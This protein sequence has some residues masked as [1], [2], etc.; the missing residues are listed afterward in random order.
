MVRSVVDEDTRED[1]RVMLKALDPD[2]LVD[3]LQIHCRDLWSVDGLYYIF[4]EERYD[5]DVATDIDAQVWQTMGKIEARRLKKLLGLKDNNL[6]SFAEAF[7]YTSWAL[8]LEWKEYEH[9]F[10]NGIFI[11]RNVD[12]R[13]QN[14]RLKKGL[15]VFA[16]KKVRYGFMSSFAKEFNPDIEVECVTCPPDEKPDD[17]WCEWRFTIKK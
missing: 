8:D 4:I 5:T 9:D 16:C 1:D 14:T 17:K 15:P 3:L 11:I 10:P 2:K 12:C 7:K 6:E 13:V